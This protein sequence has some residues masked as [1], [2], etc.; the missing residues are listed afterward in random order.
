[1]IEKNNQ[2]ESIVGAALIGCITVGV[3]GIIFAFLSL[4][5]YDWIGAG[6]SLTASG[7]AFGL[8]SNAV[9]RD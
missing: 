9:L 7:L 6:L 5:N 4:F 3:L 2:I 8:L 1:M